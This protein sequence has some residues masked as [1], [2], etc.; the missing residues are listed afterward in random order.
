MRHVP[1]L[2]LSA[3]IHWVVMSC[4]PATSEYIRRG[5]ELEKAQLYQEALEQYQQAKRVSPD[6]PEIDGRILKLKRKLADEQVATARMLLE[7]NQYMDAAGALKQA[8]EIAPSHQ[9]ARRLLSKT[10]LSLL[11][12][13]DR[14][15]RK[16][17]VVE[18]YGR[19]QKLRTLFPSDGQVERAISGLRQQLAAS[20]LE[21]ARQNLD[22]GL[23]G[24]AF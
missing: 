18:A 9:Q 14:Q 20:L 22:R 4:A 12:S 6:D 19:A 7:Q 24:N 15:A 11:A 17:D 13:I 5:E 21:K 1:G 8:I 2:L 10:I 3:L 16:G 23:F